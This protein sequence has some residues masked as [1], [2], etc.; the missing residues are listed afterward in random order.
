M[1]GL[2]GG[3]LDV[4]V[5]SDVEA[6]EATVSVGIEP[7]MEG[8]LCWQRLN[9]GPKCKDL[10]EPILSVELSL[11]GKLSEKATV[12]VGLVSFSAVPLLH[13]FLLCLS[14]PIFSG[15]SSP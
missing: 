11:S 1:G 4:E 13:F 14:L 5:P 3:S 6:D 8:R 10:Q 9:L 12:A 7:S 15:S 2:L